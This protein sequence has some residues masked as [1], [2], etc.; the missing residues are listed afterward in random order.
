MRVVVEVAYGTSQ[1]AENVYPGEF[2]IKAHY[3]GSGLTKDTKFD[4]GKAYRLDFDDQWFAPATPPH[5]NVPP[6]RGA[7]DP[8]RDQ[9]VKRKLASAHAEAKKRA[10]LRTRI[11]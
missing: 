4:L 11:S 10:R 2:V 7:L 9:T 8:N 5:P 6:K 3:P 1:N